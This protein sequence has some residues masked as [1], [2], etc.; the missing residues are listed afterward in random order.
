MS[1]ILHK[2]SRAL[3]R[4]SEDL[5]VD[6]FDKTFN[7]FDPYPEARKA[8]SNLL[9]WPVSLML[10]FGVL[11]LAF[12]Q[13]IGAGVVLD[14]T[15][16]IFGVGLMVVDEASEIYSNANVFIRALVDHAKFAQGDVRAVYLLKGIMQKLRKYYVLLAV[17]F[18]VFSVASPW[19]QQLVIVGFAQFV[20]ST[21]TTTSSLGIAAP[22][23]TVFVFAALVTIVFIV[24]G[25]VKTRL[26][27]FAPSVPQAVMDEQFERLTVMS[28]WGEA[29]PYELSH[30]PVFEDPEVEERK[31]RA[32]RSKQ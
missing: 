9:L 23:V 18:A 2:K 31:R 32:L 7:V 27:E 29:P 24:A 8:T 13:L 21:V 26:F 6:A 16:V 30:R 28:H 4:A 1:I 14:I 3:N 25:Q 15:I 17:V 19:I 22:Y 12:M 11:S 20:G 10:V 5:H